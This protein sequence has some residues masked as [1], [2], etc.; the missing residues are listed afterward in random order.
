MKFK[1]IFAIALALSVTACA[2]SLPAEDTD[3]VTAFK[4]IWI[5]DVASLSFDQKAFMCERFENGSSTDFFS[6]TVFVDG[7]GYHSTLGELSWKYSDNTLP[8][9]NL[10]YGNDQGVEYVEDVS[11]DE[12]GSALEFTSYLFPNRH[13]FNECVRVH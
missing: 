13:G 10:F 5:N 3:D 6:L 12:S 1:K 4:Q 9:V 8:A 7:T 2:N 11:V